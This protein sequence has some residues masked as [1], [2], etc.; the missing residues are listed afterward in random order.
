M[1]SAERHRPVQRWGTLGGVAVVVALLIVALISQWTERDRNR[2][3]GPSAVASA[4]TPV[5]SA[6][7][8]D[9]APPTDANAR[10]SAD[11][12]MQ[13]LWHGS[14]EHAW[15]ILCGNGQ[16]KY[17]NG[18]ALQKALGLRDRSIA[19]Y[20]ITEVQPASFNSDQRKLVKVQVTYA[21]E[22]TGSLNLSVTQE[23]GE[24]KICGF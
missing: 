13:D 5:P 15:S 16:D 6:T 7:P 19:G 4:S 22:G 17:E 3:P 21:P 18:A 20:T 2:P 23:E 9:A 8:T 11:A 24:A 12:F 14:Y 10:T 1:G